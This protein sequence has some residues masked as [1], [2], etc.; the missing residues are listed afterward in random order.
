MPKS[1]RPQ[2]LIQAYELRN[3]AASEAL[4]LKDLPA[5]KPSDRYARARAIKDLA[6]VWLTATER[7][8]IFRNRGL[9]KA[10]EAKNAKRT[11]KRDWPAPSK[12]APTPVVAPPSEPPGTS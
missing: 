2:G 9:P 1:H 4:A 7:I 6:S 5:P 11:A 12:P 10:V 8:R 3:L